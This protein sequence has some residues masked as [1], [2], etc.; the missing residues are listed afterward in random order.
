MTKPVHTPFKLVATSSFR[1]ERAR[2]SDL[3]KIAVYETADERDRKCAFF[4][5]SASQN[6]LL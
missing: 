5:N 4:H 1:I 6:C 3:S 2:L